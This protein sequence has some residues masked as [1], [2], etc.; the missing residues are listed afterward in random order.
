MNG[1]KNSNALIVE[2]DYNGELRYSTHP[3]PCVQNYDAQN[4]V[5]IGSFSKVLLPS[6]RISYIVMPDKLM[7]EYRKI[8]RFTNQTASK[9]EQLAL[10]RYINAGKI[11][12]QLRKARRVYFE[13]SRAIIESVEKHFD[14]CKTVFNETSLYLTI[15]TGFQIN[16]DK[17]KAE[18]EA[19][20]VSVMPLQPGSSEVSLSFS[21]I[22][23]ERIDKGIELLHNIISHI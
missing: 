6:V 22:P 19:N 2:D 23:I 20:S 3:V 14:G 7:D 8:S 10:A 13:K 18:L 21:G 17:L 11:D 16:A 4:T 9:I 5:Y 15:K 12:V 1:Q